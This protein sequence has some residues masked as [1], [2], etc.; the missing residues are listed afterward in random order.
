MGDQKPMSI[1]F[2]DGAL[3][4]EVSVLETRIT[5]AM[6]DAHQKCVLH[7]AALYHL[8]MAVLSLHL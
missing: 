4:C 3:D 2:A 5:D 7:L 6:Q 8:S 1:E